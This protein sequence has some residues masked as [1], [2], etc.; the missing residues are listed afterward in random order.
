VPIAIHGSSPAVV[1]SPST[2]TT[3][4][5]SPPAG[6][7]LI[8]VV[9]TNG[10]P[11]VSN[12]GTARTWTLRKQHATYG[13]IRIYTAPNP[14]A[15]TTTVSVTGSS[16]SGALKVYVITGAHTVDPIGADGTGSSAA[17]AAT[18]NAYTSTGTNSRGF[19]GAVNWSADGGAPTST[20]DEAAW[21]YSSFVMSGLAAVKAADT[22]V[23]G[24]TVQFHFDGAGTGAGDWGWVALEILPDSLDATINASSVDAAADIPAPGLS[25][26]QTIPAAVVDAA[27][28]VPSP[29][30][31]AGQTVPAA[32]VDAV[33]DIP[34]PSVAA[35]SAE[36]VEPATVTATADIPTPSV[37]AGQSIPATTVD[38]V[39][40]IPTPTITSTRQSVISPAA[41]DATADIPS[42]TITVPE[43]P[44][45]YITQDGQVEWG[46][47]LWGAGTSYAVREVTGWIDAKPQMD[48]LTVEE[49]FRHGALAGTS[50]AKRR[51]VTV[52][53]QLNS[54]SDPTQISG[55]LRQ[56][57]YDTRTLRDNTLWPLVMRGY[58]EM[59]LAFGK[60]TDRTGV[61][62]RDYSAGI[63]EP[64][65][66]I[67]CPDP[68][69]Y[70]LEQQSTVIA[71][72][73]TETVVNGGDCYTSPIIRFTGPAEN[74]AL[75][76]ETL[77][78]ILAFN[79]ELT[80]GQRLDVNTLTGKVLIGD[81]N[82]MR[83]LADTISVP[84]KEFF[85]DVGESVL[86]YETDSGGTNG[87]EIIHRDAYL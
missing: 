29:G 6:S 41:V 82:S 43:L 55:L 31:S 26:G 53:L 16:I 13:G 42:P 8:A 81:T 67:M 10:T 44:G 18:V 7:L 84:P 69:C 25:A 87:V 15:I 33:A 36:L 24:S 17:N 19:F 57:R 66:T 22:A 79:I 4:S 58:T 21:Y 38:A 50:Y 73:G 64:V 75:L 3:A 85:L 14:T 28:D 45:Q 11:G 76:N 39:A 30:I 34:T 60:V 51:Y 37:S 65:V 12:S 48:D 23:V 83:Y 78:R 49:A 59:L 40:D 52:K 77:D 54:V 2:L 63:T 62:D 72:G 47:V 56:L 35:G 20:D 70:S 27:A 71:A 32:T 74:P 61:W 86:T 68:R 9:M 80:S 5:F 1:V 46:G